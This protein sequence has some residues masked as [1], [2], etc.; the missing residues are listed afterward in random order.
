MFHE[1]CCCVCRNIE[2]NKMF[3]KESVQ[4]RYYGSEFTFLFILFKKTI[5]KCY[6]SIYVRIRSGKPYNFR[7]YKCII[8]EMH[9]SYHR[10]ECLFIY[11]FIYLFSMIVERSKNDASKIEMFVEVF[12]Q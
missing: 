1:V 2:N 12:Q 8:K 9:L 6:K 4:H 5:G 11:L 10:A 3:V 7:V